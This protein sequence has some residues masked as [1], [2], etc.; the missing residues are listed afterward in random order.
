[1]KFFDISQVIFSKWKCNLD[2]PLLT[3]QVFETIMER[4]RHHGDLKKVLTQRDSYGWTCLRW[5]SR[6]G[7]FEVIKKILFNRIDWADD[8]DPDGRT[9]I[10]LLSAIGHAHLLDYFIN[11][12]SK[13]EEPFTVTKETDNF[14]MTCLHRACFFGQTQV[15]NVILKAVP[16]LKFELFLGINSHTIVSKSIFEEKGKLVSLLEDKLHIQ[17]LDVNKME[18]MDTCCKTIHQLNFMA[19]LNQKKKRKSSETSTCKIFPS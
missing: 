18:I 8:L 13:H 19:S 15:V 4:I 5:A 6:I 10:H 17:D 9:I 3:S 12:D 2:C 14:G 7:N 16:E 11:L 1:M